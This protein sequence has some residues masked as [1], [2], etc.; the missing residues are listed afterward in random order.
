MVGLGET[1]AQVFELFD[2]LREVGC[3]FLTIGQYLSPSKQHLPVQEYIEPSIFEEYGSKAREKGFLFVA[4]APFVRSS[5]NA[6]EA[7]TRITCSHD[8]FHKYPALRNN[9]SCGWNL[10]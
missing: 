3:E 4:S 9:R 10:P 5:Y 2:D 7:Y 6:G 1:N 8:S